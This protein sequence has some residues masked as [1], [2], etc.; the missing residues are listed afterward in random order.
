MG[1]FGANA[2]TLIH[3]A[4]ILQLQQQEIAA[5]KQKKSKLKED[6]A[7]DDAEIVVTKKINDKLVQ[8]LVAAQSL[9]KS[10][11]KEIDAEE[12]TPINRPC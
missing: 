1:T 10:T 9:F 11:L 7:A 6:I 12:Q 2:E 5:L 3:L 8:S 4:Y